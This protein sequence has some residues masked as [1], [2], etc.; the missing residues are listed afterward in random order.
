MANAH[1]ESVGI[2][3]LQKQVELPS[4]LGVGTTRSPSPSPPI[5]IRA[6]T[7]TVGMV[8]LNNGGSSIYLLRLFDDLSEGK[9]AFE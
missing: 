8:A 7:A 5:R 9:N 4:M 2:T 1:C 3:A 6:R